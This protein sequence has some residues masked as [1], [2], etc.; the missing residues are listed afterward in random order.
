[1]HRRRR[2]RAV[3]RRSVTV[4]LLSGAALAGSSAAAGAGPASLPALAPVAASAAPSIL[5]FATDAGPVPSSRTLN[6][7]FTLRLPDPGAVDRFIAAV[8][9]P[10]S[11]L[12]G[13]WL[14]PG[15]FTQRFAPP[16]DE[17]E[18]V[19]RAL[20]A[21]GLHVSGATPD[22]LSVEVTA[23]AGTVERAL[24]V[25]LRQFRLGSRSFF[26]NTSAP[27]VPAP[28]AGV[29]QGVLGLD[30]V[31]RYM[32]LLLHGAPA[33]GQEAMP[34]SGGRA[35]AASP[36]PGAAS[37]CADAS[38]AA[39]Q[40]GSFTADRLARFSGMGPLY[41][42]GDLGAG[43]RIAL[44]E[45]E[46]NL[47]SDVAAYEQCYG[48]SDQVD[49]VPVD[50]PAVDTVQPGIGEAALDLDVVLGLS[51]RAPVDV[52]QAPNTNTSEIDV[53]R[54][55]V[56]ADRDRV[57]SSSWGGC[58]RLQGA[59]YLA[60]EAPIF[61]KAAAQGQTVL[62]AAGDAGSTDCFPQDGGTDY[63]VDDPASQP[64]VVGVGGTAIANFRTGAERVWN[65][66]AQAQGAGGGGVSGS[67]TPGQF[68]GWQMPQYQYRYGVQGVVSG[69]SRPDVVTSGPPYYREV[70]DVSGNADPETGYVV[71]FRGTWQG[72]NGGTSAAAPLWASVAALVDA[73]P[74]CAA[75]RSGAPG[76]LPQGLYRIAG[77]ASSGG[78]GGSFYADAFTDVT[79]GNNAYTPDRPAVPLLYPSTSGYDMASGLGT[80]RVAHP[81]LY[82]PGIAAAMCFAYA[83]PAMRTVHVATISPAAGASNA[84]TTVTITGSGFLPI[85]GADLVEVGSNVS[86]HISCSS[87][88]RCT[89]QI[90]AGTAGPSSVRVLVESFALSNAVPFRRMPEGYFLATRAGGVFPVGD[91][92]SLGGFAVSNGDAAVGMAAT[93]D[94]EGYYAVTA[95]G[96]VHVAGDATF[97]G[98]LA[99]LPGGG[100]VTVHDIVAIA[101]TVDG[102]G[103]WL[104]GSDGGMFAFGDARFHGSLPGRGARADDIVGLVAAPS[105]AGYDLV[106]A[107]GGVFAFGATRFFGS[108]PGLGVRVD[109]IR[110]LLPAPGGTGYVLVGA[111]GGAFSFGHGAPF[112]GSL[113]GEGIRVTDIAGIALTPDGAGYWMAGAGGTTYPFGDAGAFGEPA[114]IAS[115]LPV[116]A[117][118]AT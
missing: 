99:H 71:Y 37:P 85:H 97:H 56:D 25:S 113:P 111:D 82:D 47:S 22:H 54:A 115:H 89:A 77:S 1:M 9:D 21:E 98:D 57:V 83:T 35:A 36:A 17:V 20:A 107:D 26:A 74:W 70:P 42:L 58:E 18:A 81:A 118:A 31:V 109:D 88:T 79:S 105:G 11:P 55:I 2:V 64:Y 30:D 76:A 19:E 73:S 91:A 52:F 28:V 65:D 41:A 51:P 103:Y 86:T 100:S 46:P 90:P 12:F 61:A 15:Q 63:S 75:Y 14:A 8:N 40:A 110:G 116:A 10:R 93:G 6:L 96:R 44:V 72:G 38:G 45:L 16:A 108:L 106:G 114:G 53:F 62:A 80:P 50:Q 87:T 117:I 48:I 34:L 101:P 49:Y 59:A 78:F 102:R 29:V 7:Q 4:A 23:S 92:P 33:P 24:H 32:P 67:T 3:T 112:A 95:T 66:S 69:N 104:I 60:S 94:G 43:A 5:R 68:A 84:P 39:A 27:E 13:R